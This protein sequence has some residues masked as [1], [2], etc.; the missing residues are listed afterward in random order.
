[1]NWL[2]RTLF[3][4]PT[5]SSHPPQSNDAQAEAQTSDTANGP[6]TSPRASLSDGESEVSSNGSRRST[7]SGPQHSERVARK[8]R[9][10]PRLRTS[11][12]AGTL[13]SG[14]DDLR[15]HSRKAS[16]ASEPRQVDPA[17]EP[18]EAVLISSS[19][20]PNVVHP[21]APQ[22]AFEPKSPD[23]LSPGTQDAINEEIVPAAPPAFDELVSEGCTF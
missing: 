5:T 15:P 12:A 1:M 13:E 16:P 6:W 9:S 8:R 23:P 22:M 7:N 10:L 19:A 4:T 18:R 2:W 11:H 21:V 20:G 14:R 17:S 3:G